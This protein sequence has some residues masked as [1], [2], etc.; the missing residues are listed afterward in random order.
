[1]SGDRYL[2]KNQQAIHF[3]TFTVV[4]WVDVFTRRI[5]K[6]DITDSLNY[7]VAKKGLIVY[8]WCLMSNHLH[9]VAAVQN[10]F[11]LSDVVRDLKKYTAKKIINRIK[12]EPE[13]RSEW[14]L[15][16]FIYAGRNLKNIKEYKFWKSGNHA[17]ELETNKLKQQKVDYTH[18][19]PVEAGIVDQPEHYLYSSARDY[20][21]MKGLVDVVFMN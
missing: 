12:N 4:G 9:L 21:G 19:N 8:G 6:E 3:L 13:S 7:C 17:I 16:Q 11:C 20:A 18:N 15:N 1:M 5:Y 10:K 2:I 14:M